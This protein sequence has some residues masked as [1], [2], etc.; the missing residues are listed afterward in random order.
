MAKR[1]KI[2]KLYQVTDH[3]GGWE[4]WLFRTKPEAERQ[5]AKQKDQG[6][7]FALT[8]LE[9]GDEPLWIFESEKEIIDYANKLCKKN[10]GGKRASSHR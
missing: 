4:Y 6:K 7:G 2:K 5:I 3:T 1:I 9:L 8:T 10:K